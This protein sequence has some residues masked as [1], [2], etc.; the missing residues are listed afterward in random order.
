MAFVAESRIPTRPLSY[1]YVDQAVNKELLV[2]YDT[3]EIYVKDTNGNIHNI[4]A[5]VADQIG[6]QIADDPSFITDN[7]TITIT[8]PETGEETEVSIDQQVINNYTYI[9]NVE[10]KVTELEQATNE[11]KQTTEEKLTEID[12]NKTAIEELNKALNDSETGI[13]SKIE[14]ITKNNV[15]FGTII[16]VDES[17]DATL[18]AKNITTDDEYQ[19][20]T[21][22]QLSNID[23]IGEKVELKYKTVTIRTSDW[24]GSEPPYVATLSIAGI[25]AEM[26]PTMDLICSSYY[27]TSQKEE[28]GFC[29]YKGVTGDGTVTLY[30]RVLP[31]VDLTVQFEIKSPFTVLT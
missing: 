26:R 12:E 19:F 8:D 22:E 18:P 29:I 3:G 27:E 28:D 17:G 10:N 20:V 30:N 21:S 9:T 24:V 4:T 31:T 23:T 25:T 16:E 1:E 15:A 5:K 2:D 7:I 14:E 11:F 6:D 13:N